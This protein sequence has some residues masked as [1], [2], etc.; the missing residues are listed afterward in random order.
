M[1]HTVRTAAIGWGL[2]LALALLGGAVQAAPPV[3]DPEAETPTDPSPDPE[4]DLKTEPASDPA[5]ASGAQDDEA[6]QG[7][8]VVDTV[9]PSGVR[10]IAA[11]DDTLPVAAIVL[12]IETGSEDD[13]ENLPGLHHAFAYHLLQ[14]NREYAPAAIAQLAHDTGGVAMLATGPA[15][16]RFESLVPVSMLG[17]MMRAEASRLRAPTMQEHLWSD[18]LTWAR[19][20]SSRDWSV[21]RQALA[22]AHGQPSLAHDGRVVSKALGELDLRQVGALMADRIGYDRATLVVVAPQAPLATLAELQPLFADLPPRPRNV[23]TRRVPAMAGTVPRTLTVEDA[24]SNVFVWPVE[25]GPAAV[26][27]AKVW[28]RALNRQRRADTD[29]PRSRVRCKLDEDPRRGLMIVRAIGT[30]EPWALVDSRLQRLRASDA[31]L[32]DRERARVLADLRVQLRTPLQLARALAM[33]P[34]GAPEDARVS[35]SIDELTGVA[36]L[37]DESGDG[38]MAKRLA[39]PRAVQLVPGKVEP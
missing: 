4:T 37:S 18:S 32:L 1:K 7:P 39:A 24:D 14:G 3:G 33:A 36:S 15:Q 13:P 31:K 30:D 21:P 6:V 8:V 34:P 22:L 10:V 35:K 28:C 29:P 26:G 17:E 23:I 2:G 19:R 38:D 20:D 25:P 27:W 16:I 12:A 5:V 11:Q 9:L